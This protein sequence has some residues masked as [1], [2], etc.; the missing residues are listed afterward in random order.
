MAVALRTCVN[1]GPAP[2]GVALCSREYACTRVQRRRPL[3]IRSCVRLALG[4][5]SGAV[6]LHSG[7]RWE[8]RPCNAPVPLRSPSH[9]R[10]RGRGRSP[11]ASPRRRPF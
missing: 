9:P 11:P 6:L 10:R 5:Q 8:I 3:A 4:V 7:D 2:V 1:P